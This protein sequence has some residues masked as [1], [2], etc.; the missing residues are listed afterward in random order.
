MIEL[1]GHLRSIP[2]GDGLLNE[3]ELKALIGG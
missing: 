2:L 1:D 3:A